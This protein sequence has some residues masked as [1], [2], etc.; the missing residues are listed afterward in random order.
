MAAAKPK[1]P[2]DIDLRNWFAG[3]ILCGDDVEYKSDEERDAAA[4]S[5][6]AMADSMV[7]ASK[8]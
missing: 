3:M 8:K 5:Y 1:Q 4:K 2:T 7:K 6:F